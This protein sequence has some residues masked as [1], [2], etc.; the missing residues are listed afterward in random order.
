MIDRNKTFNEYIEALEF[1]LDEGC[2]TESELDAIRQDVNSFCDQVE[3]Y[4]GPECVHLMDMYLGHDFYL[5]RHRHGAGFWDGDY[6]H[7]L[8][9]EK[10]T[11]ISHG[12][13]E[14]V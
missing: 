13:S 8:G 1:C 4:F 3:A 6:D 2:P 14:M 7:I 10:L 9:H 5:T 12:F 11:E